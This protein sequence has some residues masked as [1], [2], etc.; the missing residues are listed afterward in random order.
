MWS[1]VF[2]LNSSVKMPSFFISSLTEGFN[3]I[4]ILILCLFQCLDYFSLDMK[5]RRLNN[6]AL[7]F[8]LNVDMFSHCFYSNPG[9][10]KIKKSLFPYN[11]TNFKSFVFNS[12]L[13]YL[14]FYWRIIA[15]HNC[16]GF[17]Q[18]LTWI[19]HRYTYVLSLLNLP[20]TCVHFLI[21][22]I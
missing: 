11:P 19:S 3:F 6:S 15:L 16:V 12:F 7:S 8:G 20:P 14:F 4:F 22:H 5:Q 17:C 1:K 13:K 2:K 10:K 18:T 9:F 21:K